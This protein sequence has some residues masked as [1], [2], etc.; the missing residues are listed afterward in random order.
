M[1]GKDYELT[2]IWLET[3]VYVVLIQIPD[4]AVGKVKFDEGV[5]LLDVL[6]KAKESWCDGYLTLRTSFKKSFAC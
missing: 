3:S 1:S 5:L 4:I 6:G 2:F